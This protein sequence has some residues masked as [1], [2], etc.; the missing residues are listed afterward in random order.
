MAV[1][2]DNNIVSVCKLDE[3]PCRVSYHDRHMHHNFVRG[4]AWDA[5]SPDVLHTVG[6]DSVI[7]SHTI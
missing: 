4:M 2:C 7:Q 6:W 1:C 5:G 3:S